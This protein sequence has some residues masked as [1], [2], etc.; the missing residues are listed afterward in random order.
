MPLYAN[1]LLVAALPTTALS[2]R[3]P[4]AHAVVFGGKR[5]ENRVKWSTSNFRGEFLIHA[6]KGMTQRE[7]WDALDFA[8]SRGIKEDTWK[9]PGPKAIQRGGIVGV[10]KVTGVIRPSAPTGIDRVG[11]VIIP[12][13]I[14]ADT[15]PLTDLEKAWWMGAFALLLDD[16]RPLPFVECAGM[17]GWF[18]V[19]DQVMRKLQ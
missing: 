14:S 3:Q 15:R 10:A 7:Y 13:P 5:V 8:R 4:W 12:M 6:A 19:P 2:L 9:P 1:T 17:L 18:Q 11:Q 16:V